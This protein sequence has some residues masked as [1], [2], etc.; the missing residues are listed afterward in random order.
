MKTPLKKP[1]NKPNPLSIDPT[2]VQ[3]TALLKVLPISIVIKRVSI[4]IT[5]PNPKLLI[6]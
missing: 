3:V 1:K 6:N 2:P 4:K 5:I